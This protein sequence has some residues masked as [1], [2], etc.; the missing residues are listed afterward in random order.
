MLPFALLLLSH[1]T[2]EI[3]L[4]SGPYA[5]VGYGLQTNPWRETSLGGATYDTVTEPVTLSVHAPTA[6]LCY[7]AINALGTT[8]DQAVR[9]RAGESDDPVIVTAQL[10]GS[11][12]RYEAVLWGITNESILTVEPTWQEDVAAF[13]ATVTITW[14]RSIWLDPMTDGASSASTTVAAVASIALS[15]HDAV[16]PLRLTLASSQVVASLGATVGAQFVIVAQH[17]DD[18]QFVEAETADLTNGASNTTGAATTLPRGGA[19]ARATATMLVQ[20]T[21]PSAL[22]ARARQIGVFCCYRNTTNNNWITQNTQ[23]T[24]GASAF[25]GTLPSVVLPTDTIPRI[26][27]LG[28]M[29]VS[30]DRSLPTS[31]R[32][33]VEFSGTVAGGN[34][35]VDYF[36]FVNLDEPNRVLAIDV[37]TISTAIGFSAAAV[38]LVLDA[39]ALTRPY[40]TAVFANAGA[41]GAIGARGDGYIEQEGAA[42]AVAVLATGI[43]TGNGDRFRRTDVAGTTLMSFVATAARNR[44]YRMPE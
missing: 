6:A 18:I 20:L 43:Q 13:V 10:Q 23:I 35:D 21:V 40:P 7:A 44:A 29:T 42:L 26:A 39:N 41:R 31:A 17:V 34:F 8:L 28:S 25:N 5:L 37:A 14:V 2:T 22:I 15:N 33:V 19:F 11:T 30:D 32:Y 24:T 36:C 27:Y 16:S 3:D 9:W 1:A 4:T 38:D 12:T